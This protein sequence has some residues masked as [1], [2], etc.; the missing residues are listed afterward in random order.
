MQEE[1]VSA[2]F[3]FFVIHFKLSSPPLL[4]FLM[5]VVPCTI[6]DVN[7]NTFCST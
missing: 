4:M 7:I 6:D 3:G 2:L 1:L 5:Q